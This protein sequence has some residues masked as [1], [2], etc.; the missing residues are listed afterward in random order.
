[1]SSTASNPNLKSNRTPTGVPRLD[2][3]LKGGLYNGGL[4]V[5][6]GAPGLGKTILANQCCYAAAKAGRPASFLSLM[7]ESTGRLTS[8][9]EDFTFV[10]SSLVGGLVEYGSAYQTLRD[11]GLSKLLELIKKNIIA[12]K[13]KLLVLDGLDSVENLAGSP[14]EYR[15]FIYSLQNFA[16]LLKCT[17]LLLTPARSVEERMPRPEQAISDGVIELTEHQI[18]PRAVREIQILKFRGSDFLK[19]RHEIE[20]NENGLVVHPRTEVQFGATPPV[21]PVSFRT[22]LAFGVPAFDK[23][24]SGGVQ[25]GSMTTLIGAPGTGKTSLGLS[26]LLEGARRGEAGV[27]FGFYESAEELIEKAETIGIPVREFVDNGLIEIQWQQSVE[28]IADSLAERLLERI[29]ARNQKGVR[30][31]IDGMTGFRKSLAYP[32]RFGAFVSALTNELRNIGATTIYSEETDLF[33]SEVLLPDRAMASVVDNVFFLR[34]VELRSR[35]FRLISIMKMRSSAYDPHIREF[36]I[37][38][39]GISVSNS[40]SS[41]EAILSGSAKMVNAVIAEK[42]KVKAKKKKLAGRQK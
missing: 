32:E 14:A 28:N 26:F 30:V 11:H 35:L 29:R 22:R 37:T 8:Y 18:G 41:A 4:Y 10:D 9:L 36:R 15:E 6:Q 27:Y 20:I 39:N 21:R 12:R 42:E 5:V 7:A 19:G 31:F 17:T 24:V 25:A 3:L 13:A 34:Y 2:L 23:M 1:M 16:G 40:F 38:S 33:G